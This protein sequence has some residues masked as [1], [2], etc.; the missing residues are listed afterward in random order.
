VLRLEHGGLGSPVLRGATGSGTRIA[1]EPQVFLGRYLL[2]SD[3]HS[4]AAHI[5]GDT[6]EESAN[7]L[8][9]VIFDALRASSDP[10]AVHLYCGRGS[11]YYAREVLP[12]VGFLD[13]LGIHCKLELGEHDNHVPDLGINFPDYLSRRTRAL[14]AQMDQ[15][16]PS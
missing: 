8:D 9:Q 7:F 16:H 11:P 6:S 13:E 5:A 1:G 2:G 4:I 15:P 3:G 10:P 12:L 14:L